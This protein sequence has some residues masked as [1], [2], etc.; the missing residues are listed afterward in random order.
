MKADGIIEQARRFQSALPRGER[1]KL[2]RAIKAKVDDFNP[3]S[4]EGSDNGEKVHEI[5][6]PISIRAPARGATGD[7]QV[8]ATEDFI[9]I[10]APARGATTSH[11]PACIRLIFQSALPRGE[12]P[13]ASYR[14]PSRSISIR[15]PAR[16]ATLPIAFSKKVRVIS[17]R[18]PARGAT[19]ST[20]INE[21]LMIYFNPRS[22]EGSDG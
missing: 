22:R 13:S 9:S 2:A 7:K 4:R 11:A 16:G 5:A 10:R 8:V 19:V 18:A 6:L 3:R 1:L 12:R 20:S 17:I 21:L 14:P 15:A